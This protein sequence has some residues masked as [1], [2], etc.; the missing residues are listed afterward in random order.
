MST[1]AITLSSPT[2]RLGALVVAGLFFNAVLALIN[3]HIMPVGTAHVM[4]CEGLI[5]AA[6]AYT[7]YPLR[8]A[9]MKPWLMLSFGFAILFV[10]IVLYNA[11][12]GQSVSP[13]A[14][15]DIVLISTFGMVGMAYAKS[16]GDIIPLIRWIAVAV[17]GVML[18]ENYATELYSTLFQVS[19]YYLN[20]R[21]LD[22]QALGASADDILFFNTKLI[23]GR[24]SFGFLTSHRLSSL[25]L[26]QTTLGNFAVLLAMTT[27]VL[28]E[29][30][31][32]RDRTILIGSVVLCLLGTDSRI[33]F[34]MAL[35]TLLAHTLAPR[36]PTGL[37]ILTMPFFLLIS[38]FIFYDPKAFTYTNDDLEGRFEWALTQMSWIDLQGLLGGRPDMI[39]QSMDSGYSY[40]VYSQTILGLIALWI[41][42][43]YIS[44][45]KNLS[46]RRLTF[47]LVMFTTIN[48]MVG[49]TLF[50]IKTSSLL[51]FLIGYMQVKKDKP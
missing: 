45:Q 21:G 14:L 7:L 49:P 6:A 16:G 3:A 13:K 35:I 10:W 51:W 23:E 30:L 37:N 11:A 29:K 28:W 47:F 8:D 32:T 43:V 19:S 40:I 12:L 39:S 46:T 1:L 27:S 24:F 17:V 20:T 25:F 42:T 41:F 15:R 4:A 50:S 48:L 31:T 5:I 34:G 9:A 33:A 36:V 38:A 22:A 44:T 18:F 26:E 2:F